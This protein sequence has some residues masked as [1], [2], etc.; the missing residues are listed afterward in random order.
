MFGPE[1][2]QTLL[3]LILAGLSLAF[4]LGGRKR[5]EQQADEIKEADEARFKAFLAQHDR[6]E[7]AYRAGCSKDMAEHKEQ[8]LRDLA[9]LQKTEGE[10]RHELSSNMNAQLL[11]IREGVERNSAK[12]DECAAD[13]RSLS[14]RIIRATSRSEC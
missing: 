11:Q 5:L 2:Y 13:R 9:A 7:G 4:Y 6:E 8:N 3:S 14:E 12:H 1:Q 10:L